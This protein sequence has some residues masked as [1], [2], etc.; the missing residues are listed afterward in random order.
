MVRD[1]LR[2]APPLLWPLSFAEEIRNRGIEGLISTL[3]EKNRTWRRE[4]ATLRVF[5][6]RHGETRMLR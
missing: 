6:L 5:V 3:A 1:L 2:F 4:A